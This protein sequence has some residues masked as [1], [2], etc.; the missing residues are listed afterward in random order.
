MAKQVRV[1][2]VALLE[3]A[4]ESISDAKQ[5]TSLPIPVVLNLSSWAGEKQ[6]KPLADWLVQELNRIYQFTEKQCKSWVENQQLL[7]LLD[8][9]DE[10]KETKRE[11]CIIAINQFLRENERTEMV[12]CCRIKDYNNI[13]E[14]LQFQSAVFY[15]PLTPEQIERYFHDAEEELS[16]VNELRK[17]EKAIQKL[18]KSPLI[19]NI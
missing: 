2:L 10:V 7:L 3:I 12:V 18:L 1:K 13:S 19:L 15:K 6:Q 4:R 14:K 16:A 8:G 5:D 17:N 9:L 11:A